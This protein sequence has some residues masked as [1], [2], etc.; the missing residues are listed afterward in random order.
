MTSSSYSSS[1]VSVVGGVAAVGL[2]MVVAVGAGVV[3][4]LDPPPQAPRPIRDRQRQPRSK[5]LDRI[6]TLLSRRIHAAGTQDRHCYL[7][8]EGKASRRVT[9]ARARVTRSVRPPPG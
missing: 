1:S 8:A 4:S 9:R 5:L 3:G 6:N 2:F 7:G